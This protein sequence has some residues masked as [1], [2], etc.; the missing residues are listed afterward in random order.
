MRVMRVVTLG[1]SGPDSAGAARA[2]V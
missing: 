1:L 2:A